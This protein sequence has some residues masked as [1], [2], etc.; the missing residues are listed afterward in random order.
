[1][2]S[3]RPGQPNA[4]TREMPRTA[5]QIE[6]EAL[7]LPRGERVRLVE[8]LISSLDEDAEIE[9]SWNEEIRRRVEELHSG[10]VKAI[11]GEEVF[12]EIEDLLR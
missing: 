10:E 9:R 8:A 3:G 5:D 7:S 11:P 2:Q 6:V 4:E 12:K 1:M